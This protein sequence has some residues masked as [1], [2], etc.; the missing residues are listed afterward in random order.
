L[1][2]AREEAEQER[3]SLRATIEQMAEGLMI[4]D[5]A[6]NIVRANSS[7]QSIFGFTHEQMLADHGGALMNGRFSD[8]SGRLIALYEHPVRT[9]LRE[10]R[11]VT[12]RTLWYSRPDRQRVLLSITASPFFNEQGKLTGAVSI[13]RD[14]TQQQREL[15]RLQQ[16]DKLRALGQLASGVAHNFNNALAAVI[17]YSQ[18]AI[19]KS[20]D[21]EVQKYLRVIE[22]SSKDAARMVERIQNFSRTSY[23][24]DEFMPARIADIVR[25]AIDITRPRWRNDAD[26]QGIKYNVSHDWQAAE[27][28]FINCDPSELREVFVNIIL[29]ALDAMPAGGDLLVGATVNPESIA[30]SFKDSGVGM[31]EEVK[32]RVFDPFFTTKGT[33]GLGLGL[34]ESYRIVER[35]FGNLDVES[36]SDFGTT[37]TVTLP[38]IIFKSGATK[39][40]SAEYILGKKRFLVIDDEELVIYALASLLEELGHDVFQAASAQEALELLKKNQFDLAFIDLA[41][42]DSDGI[43]TAQKIKAI[44]PSLKIVLM[45]GYSPDKVLERIRGTNCID[46]PMSKPFRLDEVQ[47]VVKK[48]IGLT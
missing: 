19:R 28:L 8:K 13:I 23:K 43:A 1:Y 21:S 48:L 29:N 26:A 33:A 46:A 15:E 14:I 38:V 39:R 17:G 16:A 37:F 9:A 10:Q 12:E 4:F 20:T 24:Q 32:G 42:P 7:A 47:A 6:A 35:H 41:M 40:D 34:S 45:S 5:E 36:Q 31:S 30:I 3:I 22:Q 2:T 27:D 25:D 11:T 44:Q 18:L